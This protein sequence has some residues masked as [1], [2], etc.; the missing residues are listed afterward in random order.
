MTTPR[1]TVYSKPDCVQC[2]WTYKLLDKAEA[3]YESLDMT[4]DADAMAYVKSLNY[5]AAPV[6]VV[7]NDDGS[8]A[9]HWKGF[10]P[11]LIKKYL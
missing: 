5:L 11:D 7:K 1:Y 2:D 8:V 6:V 4:E 3:E 9:E 10:R